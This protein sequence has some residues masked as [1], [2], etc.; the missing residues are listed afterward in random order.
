MDK[1]F[2]KFQETVRDRET[3]RATV[4]GVA[5]VGHDWVTEQQQSLNQNVFPLPCPFN[6]YTLSK[7]LFI[8]VTLF[9]ISCILGFLSYNSHLYLHC[10][11]VLACCLLYSLQPLAHYS[12]VF[13]IPGLI[14]P[15]SLPYL[16]LILVL[17]L[18][19]VGVFLPLAMLCNFSW[20]LN[21]T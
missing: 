9:L 17:S 8:S 13:Y 6:S 21:M 20:Y 18:Q 12:S 1:S 19:T 15:I 5:R 7:A 11:S 10:W 3:W 14:I 4:H 2:S 16:V